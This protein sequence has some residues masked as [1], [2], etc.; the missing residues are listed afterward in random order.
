MRLRT[1]LKAFLLG[2]TLFIHTPEPAEADP[3]SLAVATTVASVAS[4]TAAGTAFTFLGLAGLPA[5][6]A[7]VAVRAALGFA[8]NALMSK[9]K[10]IS[11]GYTINELGP[12]LPHAV[13]YGKT[14]VGG[15]IFYQSLTDNS[16]DVND[17]L[18]MCIAFAGHEIQSYDTIY[19]DDDA[20]TLDSDGNVTAPSRYVGWARV[21]QYLGSD[22]QGADD[23]L[24]SEVTEWTYDHKASGIAY[25]YCRFEQSATVFP[26]GP[27]TVTALIKGKK[28]YDPRDGTTAWSDNPAL[29]LRDYLTADYGL[30]ENSSEIDDDLVGTAADVCEETVDAADRYTCNGA[31]LLDATPE[32]ICRNLISSMGGTLWYA[33]GKWGMQ[34]AKYVTPV[35]SFDEGDMRGPLKISSRHS[36]RDNF[37]GVTGVYRG[38]ATEYVEADYQPVTSATY[39]TEDGGQ[40]VYSDLPL[41]FTDTEVMARR[42][43]TIFLERNR[44]Q[45]TV[46]GVFGLKAMRVRVGDTLYLS[47]EYAGWTNKIFEVVDWK[48]MLTEEMDI[49]IAM[50]LREIDSAVYT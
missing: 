30:A 13:I 11:G 32:D 47:D 3:I 21:K 43:A 7:S 39:V 25:L 16:P 49:Q 41:I 23:D 22:S 46:T 24:V 2:S 20:V 50:I 14:R 4:A 35:V 28:V 38:A 44:R 26:N 33:N 37:N 48:F 19:F 10:Q 45:I 17:L 1:T 9:G 31:F 8:M 29:C 6:F 5:V 40:E 36:R 18:H 42:I 12:A 27:P 34:A 15:T